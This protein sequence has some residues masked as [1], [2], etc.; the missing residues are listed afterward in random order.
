LPGRLSV[1]TLHMVACVCVWDRDACGCLRV[2]ER[3]TERVGVCECGC[4]RVCVSV[5]IYASFMSMCVCV[6]NTLVKRTQ[7]AIYAYVYVYVCVSA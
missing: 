5:C 3:V 6:F 7:G 1:F 4:V 2:R